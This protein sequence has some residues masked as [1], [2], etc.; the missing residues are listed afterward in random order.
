M[1]AIFILLANSFR[2]AVAQRPASVPVN[3]S[4]FRLSR[5]RIFKKENGRT[6]TEIE[7]GRENSTNIPTRKYDINKMETCK[8]NIQAI[9]KNL[10]YAL[11]EIFQNIF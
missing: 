2:A 7:R 8:E 3:F 4:R 5:I 9:E 11:V 6:E 10:T 1:Q